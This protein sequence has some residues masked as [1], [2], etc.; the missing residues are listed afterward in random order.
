MDPLSQGTSSTPVDPP[1]KRKRGRPR[2][3]ESSVPGEKTPVLPESDNMKENKET[4]G[5]TGASMVG[6]VITGVID[7]LFDAG[8][9]V[10]V[11]VGDSDTPLRG[12]VFLPS[13][14]IPIT[15]ANDLP[16]FVTSPEQSDKQLVE[17]KKLA[18]T[19]QDKGL[20]SGFQPTVPTAKE[21]QSAPQ[22]LPLTE[23]LQSSTGPSFGGKV[24]RHQVLGSGCDNQSASAMAQMGHNKVAGQ[25]DLMLEYEASLRK[26]PNLSVKANEQSKSVSLPAPPADILPGSETAKMELEIQQQPSSDDLKVNQPVHYGV[27]SP[28]SFMEKKA[29]PKNVAPPEPAMKIISGD[30]KSHL[31]GSSIGPAANSTEANSLSEPIESFPS[32][33]FERE[34]IPSTPK[35]AAEGSPLQRVTKPQSDG[36]SG[37]TDIMKAGADTS[38]S[39]ILPATLFGREAILPE[40]KTAS[41][42]LV[43]HRMTTPQICSSPSVANNVDSNIKDVIPPAES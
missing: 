14:F 9:L 43:L 31:N 27:K 26:G 37:G 41:D 33:L 38:A 19:A 39:I 7:G 6:Q 24:V 11:K 13:R 17:L 12:L 18:P 1:M 32:L 20:Q 16:S 25:H 4:T 42:E 35:L 3:D 22:M 34:A 28:S 23:Y 30:D 15:A 5:T 40:S 8:Y 10:K 21:S 2:K 36:S 29:S